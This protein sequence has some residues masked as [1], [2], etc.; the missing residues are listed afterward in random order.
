VMNNEF[1]DIKPQ[2]VDIKFGP[3]PSLRE[4]IFKYYHEG[5]ADSIFNGWELP[6][7]LKELTDKYIE[8]L[9]KMGKENGVNNS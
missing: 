7:K 5:Y 6:S 9:I 8:E 3:E 1:F 2:L 4:M